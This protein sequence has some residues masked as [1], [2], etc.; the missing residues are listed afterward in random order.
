LGLHEYTFLIGTTV[1]SP[2]DGRMS[3]KRT[4]QV[5]DVLSIAYLRRCA[6]LIRL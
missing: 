1:Y 4:V 3:L 6:I 5:C 2:R